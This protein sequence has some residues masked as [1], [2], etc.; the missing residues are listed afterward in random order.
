[1]DRGRKV[2]SAARLLFN[3]G[4][5]I[6][7]T[8][9]VVYTFPSHIFIPEWAP[10]WEKERKA[11]KSFLK[12]LICFDNSACFQQAWILMAIRINPEANGVL[13]FHFFTTFFIINAAFFVIWSNMHNTPHSV[14]TFGEIPSTKPIFIL[15]GTKTQ[16]RMFSSQNFYCLSDS[17]FPAAPFF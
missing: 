2:D 3:D 5:K 8:H 9:S 10:G 17:S 4:K 13:S 14:H 12:I 7:V 15:L 11:S 6:L 16:K 1:M